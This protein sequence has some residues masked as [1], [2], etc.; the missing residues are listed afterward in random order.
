[1]RKNLYKILATA[2]ISSSVIGCSTTK[3]KS[4]DQANPVEVS[5]QEDTSIEKI[6]INEA[7]FS[8]SWKDCFIAEIPEAGLAVGLVF[9]IPE[10]VT[11]VTSLAY[12]GASMYWCAKMP[13]PSEL[14][15]AKNLYK[16]ANELSAA[17]LSFKAMNEA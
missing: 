14:A 17:M 10:P 11:F 9:I 2:F 5:D 4:I 12:Y 16:L 3:N 8:L 15:A 7:D 6:E 1:M 13:S